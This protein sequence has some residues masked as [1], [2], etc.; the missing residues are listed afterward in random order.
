[1]K[2]SLLH[3]S[4][5]HVRSSA[6]KIFKFSDEL[7]S[8]CYSDARSSDAFFIIVTGDIAFSGKKE[9]YEAVETLLKD[10]KGKLESEGCKFVEILMVPGNHDCVLIPENE[11]R[12]TLIN[13]IL[14]KNEL[15]EKDQIVDLCAAVQTNY[16]DFREKISTKGKI[17]DHKLL[18]EYEFLVANKV[19]R[20]TAINASWMSR[21]PEVAG[22]LIFPANK[23]RDVISQPAELRFVL[24]HHPLNWY[25]PNS[26]SELR[27]LVNT[28]ATAILSGHEHSSHTGLTNDFDLGSNLYFESKA[29][30]PHEK[31]MSAG[32]SIMSFFIDD[33]SESKNC[34]LK[35]FELAENSIDQI[36]EKPISLEGVNSSLKECLNLNDV[37]L[38][39]ISDVGGGFIH[40]DKEHLEIDDL[41]IYPEFKRKKYNNDNDDVEPAN[42]SIPSEDIL[43][44]DI[45]N[46]SLLILGEEKSGKTTVLFNS[47]KE[48]HNSGLMPLYITSSEIGNFN[49]SDLPKLLKKCANDQYK[50]PNQFLR[51]TK[52]KRVVF[53]DDI[54]RTRGGLRTILK[55]IK[56]LETEFDSIILTANSGFELSEIVNKDLATALQ[57]FDTYEITRFGH[58]LRHKL[59]RK[60]CLCGQIATLHE[61]DKKVYEIENVVNLVLGKNLVPSQ[62]FYLLILLQSSNVHTDQSELKN[63]SFA[64][65]YEY[66]MTGNLKKSGVKRDEYDELFN[67]L[68]HLAWLL[69]IIV[70][71]TTHCRFKTATQYHSKLPSIT[72]RSATHLLN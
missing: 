68:S 61:L 40:P 36:E 63:S 25:Y 59:I 43:S 10:A 21:I 67:Y 8:T 18:T 72:I 38:K 45:D 3:L 9:E 50:E 65:Y 31:N 51:S 2:I 44:P 29:L 34:L 39:K 46:L 33:G 26:S 70:K 55:F 24:V 30:Q 62:P 41:F 52:K 4:D 16:F 37:F 12:T 58:T 1:M 19:I 5:I 71:R 64:H 22:Q 27:R 23:F 66:L 56:A 11:V 32:Y 6:D 60:W 35:S 7:V 14:E 57:N 53:V 47:Y 54:D 49:T 48:M 42:F 20:F 28:H 69:S 13:S 17:L 15:A